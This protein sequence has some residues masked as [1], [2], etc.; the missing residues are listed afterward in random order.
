MFLLN[1]IYP[2]LSFTTAVRHFFTQKYTTTLLFFAFWFG[3]TVV[4]YS[5]D[6]ISYKD[7]FEYLAEYTYKDYFYQLINNFNEENK[8]KYSDHNV[9]NSKPDIYALTLGF[10]VS[11]FTNEPRWFFAVVSILYFYFMIKFLYETIRFTRIST[12]YNYKLYFVALAL[13][14]PFYVGVTGVRF[15]TALFFFLWMLVRFLN[16]RKFKYI[17]LCGLS[18]L[19]HYT[20][21]FPFIVV[22]IAYF[23]PINKILYKYIILLGLIYIPLA[24]YTSNL[25]IIKSI[26]E[27]IDQPSIQRVSAGYLDQNYLDNREK[28]IQEANWYVS[29]RS[30]LLNLFFF[31][32]FIVDF[33][34]LSKLLESYRS[35]FFNKLYYLFFIIALFTLNLGSLNRFLYIFHALSLIRCM[36]YA[37]ASLKSKILSFFNIVFIPILIL[38]V[39]VTFRAGFYFVDPLLLIGNPIVF[40]ILNSEISLSE[41]LIGH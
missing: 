3:Y 41:L 5:G 11:R 28:S 17:L 24:P 27:R 18:S 14:V 20:F 39:L 25:G 29:W 38:H 15:W 19:I 23:I 21:A 32:F 9:Y 30:K 2:F 40:L 1:L 36:Q 16:N 8:Y 12:R 31:S 22:L 33:F 13:I 4:Y 7:D 37:R 26:V 6:I 10:W 34:F 35:P